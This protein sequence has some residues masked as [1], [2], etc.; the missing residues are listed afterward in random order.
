MKKIAFLFLTL[1]N[2]NQ[3]TIWNDFFKNIPSSKYN[4]YIH[5]KYPEKVTWKKEC[6][7]DNLE[8]TAWG[9]ITRAYLSLFKKAIQDPLNFKF[10]VFSESDIPIKSFN[11]LY[12]QMTNDNKSWIKTMPI[13]K[14]KFEVV[15]KRKKGCFHH[16]ARFALSRNHIERL[17]KSD[18]SYFHNMHIGD[19]YFLTVLHLHKNEY[20]D[21][22]ITYDDW[23][24]IDNLKEK[25]KEQIKKLD[26]NK[27]K[28]KI[29]NLWKKFDDIA[30]HPKI[31]NHVTKKEFKK[32]IE[33]K[34]FF[35]RKFT[36]D[37]NIYQFKDIIINNK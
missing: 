5:P 37:S 14:Y 1:D 19:E 35:Y 30:G 16:Y 24:Y 9:H 25:I 32:I 7:I 36:K 6:I 21:F 27:N 20:H 33:C 15:L 13:T 12:I 11:E 23:D 29:E 28:K 26:P 3:P 8:E 2:I 17:L 4:I 34:S 22:P 10:I 31:I 18:L